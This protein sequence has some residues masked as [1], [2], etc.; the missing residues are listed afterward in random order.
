[1]HDDTAYLI[2]LGSI[3][4][5]SEISLR[6]LACRSSRGPSARLA[7]QRRRAYHHN[8]RHAARYHADVHGED[9]LYSRIYC[10]ILSTVNQVIAQSTVGCRLLCCSRHAALRLS[11]STR[12]PPTS[13]RY[14]CTQTT[15]HR[16]SQLRDTVTYGTTVF[17]SST[18]NH[19]STSKRYKH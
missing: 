5:C 15:Y 19:T 2:F 3:K 6:Y 11:P 7:S 4:S 16:T 14:S 10:F 13:L 8:P 1:M 9:S 17:Y 18:Y 12:P